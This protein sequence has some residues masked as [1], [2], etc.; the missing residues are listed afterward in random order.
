[1]NVCPRKK[2]HFD[3]I[4]KNLVISNPDFLNIIQKNKKNIRGKIVLDLGCGFG[5]STVI[6][7][8]F[9]KKIFAIDLT[10]PAIK[11]AKKNLKINK[12]KNVNLKQMDAENLD[13]KNNYFD[14]VFSWGVIHH[15]HNPK[16]ILKNIQKKLK[17]KWIMFYY[18][19]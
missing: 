9:A 18:G 10:F 17:K 5:A 8:K 3:K 4:N 6:L 11:N 16:K 2:K 14:F 1:M 15:S 7:S 12:I 13:F 19:L